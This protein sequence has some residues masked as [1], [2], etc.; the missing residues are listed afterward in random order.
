[1]PRTRAI[2]AQTQ[3]RAPLT[4]G[5]AKDVSARLLYPDGPEHIFSVLVRHGSHPAR[6]LSLCGIL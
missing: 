2:D 1:M 6:V 5:T 3:A 4:P